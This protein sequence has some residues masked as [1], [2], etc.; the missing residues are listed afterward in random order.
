MPFLDSI[1][2]IFDAI[3]LKLQK[4]EPL[5]YK[6][7]WELMQLVKN[8]LIKF[9]HPSTMANQS[10]LLVDFEKQEYQKDDC[11]LMIGNKTRS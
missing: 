10:V 5:V 8:L 2:P 1:I 6:L 3:Y 9:V 4:E 7:R 11:D